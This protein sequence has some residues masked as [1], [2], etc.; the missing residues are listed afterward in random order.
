MDSKLATATKRSL[1]AHSRRLTP[2]QRLEAFLVHCRLMMDL[3]R[4]GQDRRARASKES[5]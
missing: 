5:S 3:Y 4:A 2:E 1:L